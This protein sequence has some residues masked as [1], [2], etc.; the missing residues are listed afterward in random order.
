MKH[1]NKIFAAAIMLFGLSAQAQDENNP[2]AVSFGANAVDTRV[3]A[4]SSIEDQF[5]QY[6]N[7][8]DNWNIL[9]SVSYL[10]I[11][12]Y[13]GSGFTFGVTGSV[14]KIDRFVNPRVGTS[15]DYEVTNPG[16]LKYYAVDG[17]IGY[18]FMNAI[19][20]KWF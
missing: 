11:S 4:A 1:L 13:V 12:R 3:S 17:L 2:W 5:S 10:N 16:D 20:S 8:K 19:G 6:F 14:N 18:S 15:Y 9:P 7:A